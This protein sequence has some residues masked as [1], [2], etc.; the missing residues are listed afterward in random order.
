MLAKRLKKVM[1]FIVDETQSAFIEGR[2]LLHSALIAN[3]VIEEANRSSKL[4]IK[5]VAWRLKIMVGTQ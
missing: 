5:V 4:S 1:T 3:E 2:H